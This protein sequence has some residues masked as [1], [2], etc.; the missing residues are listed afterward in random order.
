MSRRLAL[1]LSLVLGALVA[2]GGGGNAGA[3][4]AAADGGGGAGKD[5][6]GG[7]GGGA[8]SDG[9]GGG[10]GGEAGGGGGPDADGSTPPADGGSPND[11]GTVDSM[12]SPASDGG[13]PP[14]GWLYTVAGKNEIYVSNGSSGTVWMGRGV[15]MDDLFLCG[16]NE[17]FWM[18]SPSGEQALTGMLSALMTDWKPTFLRVSLAMN[19]YPPY[20]IGWAADT[21]QYATLMTSFIEAIG[22]YPNTY[23]LITLR[24]EASMVNASN[25]Q[26]AA[27][28]DDAVCIPTSGTDATYKALVDTFKDKPY[29]LFGVSNEPGGNDGTQSQITSAMSHAV[30][31]IRAEEDADGVPHHLVSVQGLAYTSN[32]AFY[33]TAPLPYDNVVY[34]FHSYP[35]VASAYTQSKI[36]VIIGEYGPS[37]TDTSFTTALYADLEAKHIPNLAWDMDTFNDCAPDLATL[38][39]TTTITPSPWGQVVKAYLNAH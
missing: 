36:P 28:G 25:A 8:G 5:G 1:S 17:G 12:P 33:D 29:V 35:P 26:C 2:C 34:E 14:A 24:S 22:A 13:L 31:T 23:V 18:T 3:P 15:N 37:G 6:S 19:S 9:G 27:G 20:D 4:V 11:G 10:G 38:T 16:Y 39:T 21:S 7:G 30:A 32:I